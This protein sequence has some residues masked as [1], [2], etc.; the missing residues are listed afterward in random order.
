[1]AELIIYIYFI[2]MHRTFIDHLQEELSGKSLPFGR[3]YKI[4][5]ILEELIENN[6]KIIKLMKEEEQM[7]LEKYY[8]GLE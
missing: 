3:Q 1:M 2:Q 4:I 5:K 7:K 8:E 6:K